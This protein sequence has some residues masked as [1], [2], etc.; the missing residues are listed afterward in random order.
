MYPR[1]TA[2][3]SQ[4]RSACYRLVPV[5]MDEADKRIAMDPTQQQQQPQQQQWPLSHPQ[6]PQPFGQPLPFPPLGPSINDLQDNVNRLHQQMALQFPAPMAPLPSP[7]LLPSPLLTSP[8]MT[9]PMGAGPLVTSA[10]PVTSP[11]TF[12]ALPMPVVRLDERGRRM[13]ELRVDVS[14]YRPE[15][16]RI[17]TDGQ[18]LDIYARSSSTRKDGVTDASS[19]SEFR[20]Q[21]T[22]PEV[23][24]AENLRCIFNSDG[25]VT[26]QGVVGPKAMTQKK[27]KHVTFALCSES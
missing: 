11:M 1:R 3:M 17:H 26:I 5:A 24:N 20:R 22:L 9:S 4:P 10:A 6:Q 7:S 21:F 15:D 16:I 25:S 23:V 18:T 13:V 19:H 12:A 27:T 8:L 2:A 14:G